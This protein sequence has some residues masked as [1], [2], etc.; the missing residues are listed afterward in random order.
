MSAVAATR[1]ML[2]P[3]WCYRQALM[4]LSAR[5]FGKSVIWPL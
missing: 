1:L 5:R 4:V 2:I 3:L